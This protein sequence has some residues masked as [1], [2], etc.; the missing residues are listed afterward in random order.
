QGE[1]SR[2]LL[3]PRPSLGLQLIVET[4]LAEQFLP[5]LPALRLEQDPVHHH[6]DV[7]AHTMAVVDRCERDHT[8]RLAALL[9][10]I[11][12]PATRGFGQTAQ[13]ATWP[14]QRRWPR[15]RTTW[16]SGSPGWRSRKT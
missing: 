4:G 12:K 16:S 13:R 7:L 8:L 2:L 3:S 15:S 9:H 6:K 14:G 10:D 1:L 5:E 11:G